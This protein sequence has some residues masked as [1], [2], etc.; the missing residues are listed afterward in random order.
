MNRELAERVAVSLGIATEEVMSA[1]SAGN[2][3]W[4]TQVSTEL[5]TGETR[6]GLEGNE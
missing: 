2:F 6:E 5:T 3:K 1:I 4:Y